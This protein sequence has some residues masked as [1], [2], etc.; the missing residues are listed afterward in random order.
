MRFPVCFQTGTRGI[1]ET[2]KTP[3]QFRA[4]A[5]GKLRYRE[6]QP[7]SRRVILFTP[8]YADK[9][10]A[11]TLAFPLHNKASRGQRGEMRTWSTL[12]GELFMVSKLNLL[13]SFSILIISSPIFADDH[14]QATGA[15]AGSTSTR[16]AG[17]TKI[18]PKEVDIIADYFEVPREVV[19]TFYGTELPASIEKARPVS[20]GGQGDESGV[21]KIIAELIGTRSNDQMKN[22]VMPKIEDEMKKELDKDGTDRA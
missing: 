16:A 2:T 15:D 11:L 12:R 8:P 22:K 3:G 6:I 19:P 7:Y 21:S 13:V 1:P 20:V 9:P 10:K 4:L 14:A 5:G 17:D 18:D